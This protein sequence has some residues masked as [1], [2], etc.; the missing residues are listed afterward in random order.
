MEK[1]GLLVEKEIMQISVLGNKE[2][3][4][5]IEATVSL[6]IA[7]TLLLVVIGFTSSSVKYTKRFIQKT[8]TYIQAQNDYA[9]KNFQEGL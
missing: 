2:G 3:F 5:V 8:D 6:F 9:R 4:S 1:M 7:G